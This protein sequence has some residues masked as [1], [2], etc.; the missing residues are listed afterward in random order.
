L[1][2]TKSLGFAT[3]CLEKF[4][5]RVEIAISATEAVT[6]IKQVDWGI[7]SPAYRSSMTMFPRASGRPH[8]GGVTEGDDLRIAFATR[9]LRR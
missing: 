5:Y 4:G 3:N 2:K 7:L 1:S 9:L 8:F 6:K